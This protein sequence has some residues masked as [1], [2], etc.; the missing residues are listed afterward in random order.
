MNKNKKFKHSM[1]NYFFLFFIILGLIYIFSDPSTTDQQTVEKDY[2][3]F[4]TEVDQGN[5]ISVILEENYIFYS[6]KDEG[7]EEIV[8]KTGR[9]ADPNLVNRLYESNIK[10]KEN[11]QEGTSPFISMLL[12]ILPGIAILL[13]MYWLIFRRVQ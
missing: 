8:F 11:I 12:M 2:S 13:V 4:L 5:V 3:A 9:V 7:D 1:S 6:V 10:F